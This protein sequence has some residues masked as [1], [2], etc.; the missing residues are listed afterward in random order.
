MKICDRSLLRRQP[1]DA[2]DKY[3]APVAA[4]L[5]DVRAGGDA[6]LREYTARFDRVTLDSLHVQ[7]ARRALDLVPDDVLAALRTAAERL[8]AFHRQQPV[9]SWMTT[10]LGGVLGQ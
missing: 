3:T 6:A 9:H 7:D 2:D 5:A 4:I 8:E 10:E 1:I